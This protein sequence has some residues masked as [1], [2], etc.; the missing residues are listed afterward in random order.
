MAS[1]QRIWHLAAALVTLYLLVVESDP[2]VVDEVLKVRME[3]VELLDGVNA[4]Q[5]TAVSQ[6][7]AVGLVLVHL[8]V[9]ELVAEAAVQ[10]RPGLVLAPSAGRR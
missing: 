7:Q 6:A 10:V 1:I 5:G 3:H 9:H 2:D 4:G 8:G